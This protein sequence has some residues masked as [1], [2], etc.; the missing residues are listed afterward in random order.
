M[1][2]EYLPGNCYTCKKCLFCFT[3]EACK[4]DK[5]IKPVRVGKPQRG[6]QIYSRVFTP[7]EEL[8]AANQFL[9]SANE[10]F[11]YNSNFNVSFSFTFCSACNSKFQRLKGNDKLAKR[12]N[13]YT[14]KKKELIEGK[15]KKL[16]KFTAKMSSKSV[17]GEDAIMSSKSS[18]FVDDGDEDD[19]SEYSEVEDYGIDKIKLQ[20]IIEKKGKKTSTSKTITINPVEYINV[21]EGINNA[22]Q[23]ALKNRSIKPSDYS[24][25]YKVVNARGPSSALE[26]KLDFNEFIDDYKKII[27]VDKKM[28]VIVVIG[29]DSVNEETKSKRLKISNKSDFS[30]SD[31]ERIPSSSKKKKKS[32]ATQENDLSKE[33]QSRAETI[34]ALCE[35][36][37]CDVHKTPCFIQENRHLQLNPAR[38]QLWAREIIN[39]NATYDVPPTFPTFSAALGTLVSKNNDVQIPTTGSTAPVNPIVIQMPQYPYSHSQPNAFIHPTSSPTTIHELPSIT[40]F[41]FSLDQKYNCNNVYSKFE[42]AF[43]EEEITVNAIKDLTDE[44]MVKLGIVKIGWQKN[45][46]QA[47]QRY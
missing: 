42:N 26:D 31:E 34:A 21:I 44:Q 11:Q 18:D 35:K 4:C 3:L 47:A 32:R 17:D 5:N 7:N 23:K 33:E 28:S 8:Q 27:A 39:K 20:I 15:E 41:L 43:L 29:D 10:K 37:K 16:E 40:E 46:R 2:R 36:Y 22:V 38:L 14:K 13:A 9:F 25:S 24:L 30:A 6:Q 19:I 12:K 45:I 1:T